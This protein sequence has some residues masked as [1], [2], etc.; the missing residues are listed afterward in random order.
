MDLND[1]HLQFLLLWSHRLQ[2]DYFQQETVENVISVWRFAKF[3]F[4]GLADLVISYFSLILVDRVTWF[5]MLYDVIFVFCCRS[6]ASSLSMKLFCFFIKT[7]MRIY[8]IFWSVFFFLFT[9][10][11][12]WCAWIYFAAISTTQINHIFNYSLWILHVQK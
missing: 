6:T 4:T 3:L 8:I 5:Q 12:T 10:F 2:H 11:S 7:C 9:F 1:F